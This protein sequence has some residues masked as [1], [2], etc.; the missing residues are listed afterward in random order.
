MLQILQT[1]KRD[2]IFFMR[3]KSKIVPVYKENKFQIYYLVKVN[4]NLG[5]KLKTSISNGCSCITDFTTIPAVVTLT[6]Q[7]L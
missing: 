4:T 7:I 1:K 6:L 3:E 5:M 2:L